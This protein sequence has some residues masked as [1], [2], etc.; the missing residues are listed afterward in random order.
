[1]LCG[2]F[3]NIEDS[4]VKNVIEHIP[5][6]IKEGGYVIWTRG[7]SEP[8]RRPDVRRWFAE[9]GLEEVAFDGAPETYGVGLNRMV[10]PGLP[11]RTLPPRL[12]SFA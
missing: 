12:F 4:D 6:L 9:V 2:I 5:C 3:G 1:M 10:R 11:K 8:D 7:G